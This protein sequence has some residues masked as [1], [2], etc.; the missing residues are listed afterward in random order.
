MV[1]K[2]LLKKLEIELKE[3]IAKILAK[4][5]IEVKVAIVKNKPDN[6]R[7]IDIY[8]DLDVIKSIELNNLD[9]ELVYSIGDLIY[10]YEKKLLNYILQRV[11]EI[12]KTNGFKE[13]EYSIDINEWVAV[14]EEL[15]E[16]ELPLYYDTRCIFISIGKYK[17]KIPLYSTLSYYSDHDDPVIYIAIMVRRIKKDD[18][19]NVIDDIKK[20]LFKL[21]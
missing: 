18:I 13:N 5:S 14:L 1:D 4:E 2:N 6:I 12:M 16:Y 3:E 20:E 21:I 7:R 10:D 17:I 8:K 9:T 15:E 11:K 19:K